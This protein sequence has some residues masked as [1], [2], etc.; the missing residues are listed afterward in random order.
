MD[1]PQVVSQQMRH[2]PTRKYTDKEL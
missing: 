1:V 2:R